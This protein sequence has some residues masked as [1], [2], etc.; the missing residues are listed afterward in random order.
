MRHKT[1][2][3][4]VVCRNGSGGR[5]KTILYKC[6]QGGNVCRSDSGDTECQ[7]LSM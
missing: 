2:T 7:D 5:H 6:D 4:M 3:K 1:V